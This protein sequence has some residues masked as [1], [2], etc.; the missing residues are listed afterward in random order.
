MITTIQILEVYRFWLH[1]LLRNNPDVKQFSI[2]H[3]IKKEIEKHVAIRQN[4]VR[5]GSTSQYD[6]ALY[7]GPAIPTFLDAQGNAIEHKIV[8]DIPK[9]HQKRIQQLA[10]ISNT[11]MWQYIQDKKLAGDIKG[12][13]WKLAE[14]YSTLTIYEPTGPE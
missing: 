1:W 3:D 13:S 14:D 11:K 2:A 7:K 10:T 6:G 5:T 8:L 12:S 9:K 4:P